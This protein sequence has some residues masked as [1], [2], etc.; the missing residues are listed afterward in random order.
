MQ[1]RNFVAHDI[2]IE[3]V[4]HKFICRNVPGDDVYKD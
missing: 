3:V 1:L 2:N 4:K